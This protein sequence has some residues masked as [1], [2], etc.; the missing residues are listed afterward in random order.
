MKNAL[1]S[2]FIGLT[3]VGTA[4]NKK[5]KEKWDVS[6]PKGE[7]NYKD[8]KFTTDEGTWMNLDVSPDGKNIVFD[9]VGD[10]YI[11]PIT[12]GKAKVLREGIP[13]EIQPRFSPD[14]KKISFTSD[15]GGGDNIWVM[16]LD[17]SEAKQITKEDFRFEI[18]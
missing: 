7:W 4:Q 12:G 11:M 9:M 17:G 6:N 16:N 10:I 18:P 5:D 2:L 1:L 14:G 13:F 15:A 3:L 8:L